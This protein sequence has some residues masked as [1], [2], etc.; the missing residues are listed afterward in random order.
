MKKTENLNK[1][2]LNSVMYYFPEEEKFSKK[3]N[4]NE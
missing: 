3:K 2:K 4:E 1:P